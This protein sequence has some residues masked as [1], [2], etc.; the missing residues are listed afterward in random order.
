MGGMPL[1]GLNMHSIHVRPSSMQALHSLLKCN[2]NTPL[3]DCLKDPPQEYR[4]MGNK[5]H[6]WLPRQSTC[7]LE[8]RDCDIS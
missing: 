3:A 7:A 4:G 1:S 2:V 5:C 8:D 6:K